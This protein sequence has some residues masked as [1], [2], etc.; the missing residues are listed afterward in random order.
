MR[1][2]YGYDDIVHLT[3]EEYKAIPKVI[4]ANQFVCVALLATH[5]KNSE[6]NDKNIRI[7]HWLIDRLEYLI[8]L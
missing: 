2:L 3:P 4:L 7:A 1:I 8:E 5:K 6:L